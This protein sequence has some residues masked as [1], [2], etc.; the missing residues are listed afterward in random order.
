MTIRIAT[1]SGQVRKNGLRLHRAMAS[2]IRSRGA[3]SPPSEA[4]QALLD[5]RR[6]LKTERAARAAKAQLP[7]AKPKPAWML[8]PPKP[9][10]ARKVKAPK[11]A[12]AKDAKPAVKHPSR[13][14]KQVRKAESLEAAKK[15]Q[16][17]SAK[18]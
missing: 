4:E 9:P 15:A 17:K 18:T 5:E 13:A 12:H 11:E 7:R 6:E 16:K 3:D 1:V 14:E 10:K 8:K 2:R